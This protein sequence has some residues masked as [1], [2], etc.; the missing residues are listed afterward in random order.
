MGFQHFIL[1][2]AFPDWK[3]HDFSSEDFLSYEA[4]LSRIY[5]PSQELRITLPVLGDFNCI[6]TASGF[7]VTSS[8]LIAKW[9]E[10]GLK[11]GRQKTSVSV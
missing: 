7:L 4:K 2:S 9:N 3:P 1:Y 10:A 8:A 5:L 11:T 6:N